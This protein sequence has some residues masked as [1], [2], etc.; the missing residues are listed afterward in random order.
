MLP[1]VYADSTLKLSTTEDPPALSRWRNYPLFFREEFRMRGDIVKKIV[2]ANDYLLGTD[3]GKADFGKLVAIILDGA[4]VKDAV[5]QLVELGYREEGRKCF[6]EVVEECH[7]ILIIVIV[8]SIK[9]PC[10]T[11]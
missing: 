7:E 2:T 10:N 9:T 6:A 8:C 3:F 4:P 1:T 11:L 5:G